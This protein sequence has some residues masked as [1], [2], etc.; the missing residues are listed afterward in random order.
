MW[1]VNC[2]TLWEVWVLMGGLEWAM[3]ITVGVALL[4]K[5]SLAPS[6]LC[7]LALSASHHEASI[8]A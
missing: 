7:M 4:Q 5:P 2:Q 3:A 1:T 6:L 8:S